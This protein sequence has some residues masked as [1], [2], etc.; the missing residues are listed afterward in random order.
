MNQDYNKISIDKQFSKVKVID[1][2]ELLKEKT[3]DKAEQS[4]TP[5]VL[6]YNRFFP[7]MGN[8][9]WYHWSILNI[10]RTV[11]RLFQEELIKTF[12]WNRNLK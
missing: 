5:L 11:Q 3:Y 9:A 1:R 4:K 10:S 2:N 8:I 7:N 12:K 6:T